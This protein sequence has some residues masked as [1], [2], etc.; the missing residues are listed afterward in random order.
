MKLNKHTLSAAVLLGKPCIINTIFLEKKTL[1]FLENYAQLTQ[2]K[3]MYF[4]VFNNYLLITTVLYYLF[5]MH[6][7]AFFQHYV[8]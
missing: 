8:F 6:L 7:H 2:Q 1:F 4:T 5:S 3:V